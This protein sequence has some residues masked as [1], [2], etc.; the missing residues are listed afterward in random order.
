MHCIFIFWRRPRPRLPPQSPSSV[1]LL[2]CLSG[3]VQQQPARLC[4][5]RPSY[6]PDPACAGQWEVRFILHIFSSASP[7]HSLPSD[8]RLLNIGSI[9]PTNQHLATAIP[10]FSRA[11]ESCIASVP[12]NSD[13]T[14]TDWFGLCIYLWLVTSEAYAH[15][16]SSRLHTSRG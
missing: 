2:G 9:P 3:S 6:R 12:L 14:P 15:S 7:S 5:Y 1:S 11:M 8:H 10:I 4:R 16:M 13:W